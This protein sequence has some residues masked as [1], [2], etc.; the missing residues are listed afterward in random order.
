MN[1]IQIFS[2]EIFVYNFLSKISEEILKLNN[3]KANISAIYGRTNGSNIEN[4]I[5][6]T[7]N[8]PNVS[9]SEEYVKELQTDKN[10]QKIIKSFT[11][12]EAMGKNSLRKFNIK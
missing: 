6:L 7:L 2:F 1:A 12:D 5:D 9:N 4:S 3:A 10:I 11:I 8:L